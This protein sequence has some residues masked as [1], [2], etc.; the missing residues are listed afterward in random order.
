MEMVLELLGSNRNGNRDLCVDGG[1][2]SGRDSHSLCTVE[3][4]SC[5]TWGTTC[6]NAGG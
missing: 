1:S 3:V 5:S 2:A 6:R 4:V